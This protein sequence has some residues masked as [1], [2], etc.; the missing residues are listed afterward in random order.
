MVSVD[1]VGEIDHGTYYGFAHAQA[2][3]DPSLGIT[4]FIFSSTHDHEAPDTL[5]LWGASEFQDG[6]FPHYL[7]FVDKE[8]A[9]AINTAG[10]AE[11]H[12]SGARRGRADHAG[13]RP[14]AARPADAHRLPPAVLL[15]RRAAR[16][17]VHRRRRR[18]RGHADQ[19]EHASRIAGVRQRLRHLRFPELHSP[20][21]RSGAR[22]HGRL[23]HRRSRLRGDRRRYLPRRRRSASGRRHQSVRPTNQTY[24]FER[25]QQLGELVGDATVTALRA[26]EAAG[27]GRLPRRD[28]PLLRR[29]QQRQPQLCQSGGHPRPGSDAVQPRQ[30]PAG[31]RH[32]R[33][34]RS[35]SADLCGQHRQAAGP[36][37]DRAR[38]DLPGAQLRRRRSR[39]H[40]L[41]R[42]QHRPAV[43][44][45][46]SR[47]HDRE[48]PVPGRAVAGRV[49]IH[50]PRI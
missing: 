17:A 5:G 23:L 45:V 41:P 44:A 8:I 12:A 10:G 15:R 35:A 1:F 33:A 26:G 32:L 39:P 40:R 50:R 4:G 19:L 9:R 3:V 49:R 7:Q 34:G 47:R 36:A 30:L 24:G 13:G 37:G 2:Q 42:R 21:R 16:P 29:R 14:R 28:G 31:H 6:K 18:H 11:R 22:R 46:D 43:R 38:R 27:G 20:A 25:T 48:V